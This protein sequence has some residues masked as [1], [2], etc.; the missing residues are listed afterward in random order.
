MDKLKTVAAVFV[1]L[2]AFTVFQVI[3]NYAL[4]RAVRSE[5]QEQIERA[6]SAEAELV[7]VQKR[8]AE[9]VAQLD[10]IA[11]RLGEL[12]Q[13]SASVKESGTVLEGLLNGL[14]DIMK[15]ITA[16]LKAAQAKPDPGKAGKE[17]P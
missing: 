16:E 13:R 12:E 17:G 5:V 8:V 2:F 7:R 15:Q 10:G 3:A 14:A 9:L 1:V 11:A 4:R 6:R